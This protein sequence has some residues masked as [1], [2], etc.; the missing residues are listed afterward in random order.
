MYHCTR[1]P[2]V[3]IKRLKRAK[4]NNPRILR[5]VSGQ[6][7]LGNLAPL[8]ECGGSP[9]GPGADG[10][11][12]VTV[13]RS[14]SAAARRCRR[15]WLPASCAVATLTVTTSLL[16]FYGCSAALEACNAACACCSWPQLQLQVSGHS[17]AAGHA[18]A[19]SAAACAAPGP[20]VGATGGECLLHHLRLCAAHRAAA[21]AEQ[22]GR[23]DRVPRTPPQSAWRPSMR[24]SSP[25]ARAAR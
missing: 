17:Q 21:A 24:A 2:L 5:P 1:W 4:P 15:S 13:L 8:N 3:L 19:D 20:R 11:L 10:S 12:V 9:H 7:L 25:T 16:H 23:G 6:S 22:R 18:A 14:V